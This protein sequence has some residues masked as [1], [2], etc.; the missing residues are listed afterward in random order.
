M[1]AREW[2]TKSMNFNQIRDLILEQVYDN[3][4][5]PPPDW[6]NSNDGLPSHLQ[7]LVDAGNEGIIV[8]PGLI[9]WSKALR[10]VRT[11]PFGYF[12]GSTPIVHSQA[13]CHREAF[14][15]STTWTMDHWFGGYPAVAIALD[16]TGDPISPQPTVTNP[17]VNQTVFTFG[18]A[19]VGTGLLVG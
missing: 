17:S 14:T 3:E 1:S 5:T 16:A 11:M 6:E 10:A 7:D 13:R 18:S 12:F 8:P 15:S 19:A 4:E 2:T 9:F